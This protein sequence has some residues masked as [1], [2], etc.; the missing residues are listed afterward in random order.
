[1]PVP[2]VAISLILTPCVYVPIVNAMSYM[3]RM[4]V[5]HVQGAQP[6]C[7]LKGAPICKHTEQYA[8]RFKLTSLL[9]HQG[10]QDWRHCKQQQ[11]HVAIQCHF[12]WIEFPL[13]SRSISAFTDF[14]TP[15]VRDYDSQPP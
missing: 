12:H 15:D 9:G 11:Q 14:S 6:M 2:P 13:H 1:M 3:L 8:H 10:L 7:C 5:P 4:N